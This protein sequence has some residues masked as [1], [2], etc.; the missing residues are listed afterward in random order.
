VTGLRVPGIS[1]ILFSVGFFFTVGCTATRLM[2]SLISESLFN[3]SIRAVAK[4]NDAE[5]F[6]TGIFLTTVFFAESFFKE[7][8]C[9]ITFG[10][11][12]ESCNC[13][14]VPVSCP[15]PKI[16]SSAKNNIAV[17]CFKRLRKSNLGNL[18]SFKSL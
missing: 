9:I 18:S 15:K 8:V 12:G 1:F 11:N 13:S 14:R 5:S 6:F 10:F 4:A 17:K 3:E 2:E 16:C 7:S